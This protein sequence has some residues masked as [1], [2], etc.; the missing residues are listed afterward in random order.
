L[1]FNW[2]T[3]TYGWNFRGWSIYGDYWTE[4]TEDGRNNI[5][6]I[7][8]TLEGPSELIGNPTVSFAMGDSD[9]VLWLF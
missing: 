5:L 3:E 2:E 8:A 6:K 9:D 4:V 7:N 1:S